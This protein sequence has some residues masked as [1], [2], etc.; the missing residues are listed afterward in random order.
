M[1]KSS[2][3]RNLAS[4]AESG[5]DYSSRFLRDPQAANTGTGFPLA[6]LNIVNIIP[7]DLNSIMYWNEAT[8]ASLL[9]LVGDSSAAGVWEERARNRSEAM[10]ALMWDEALGS[11]FDYNMTSGAPQLFA[12]RDADALPIETGPAPSND[13]QVAFHVAQL[14]P[15]LTGAALPGVK[16]SPS[17]VRRVFQKVSDYLDTRQGGISAT[18]YLT[19]QQWDQPNVWPPLMQMI[20]EGLLNTP[21]TNGEEDEDWVWTQD[22]ALRLGQRY[23]D[24]AYCTW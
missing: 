7:V 13:T 14:V 12:P 1:E 5:W 20:M 3:Y 24:S 23:L 9:A 17:A 2:Q 16:N 6:S 21:A 22:L 19:S 10:A 4:G 8:I 11:Y 15:F 18:N